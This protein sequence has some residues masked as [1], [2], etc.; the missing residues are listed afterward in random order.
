[1]RGSSYVTVNGAQFNND[2]DYAEWGAI[3]PARGLERITFWLNSNCQDGSGSITVTVN[4]FTSNSLPFTVR[5]GNIFFIAK[6]G[7]DSNNGQ[8]ASS[9]GG[10]NGPWLSFYMSHGKRNATLQAGDIVYIRQGEYNEVDTQGF[11]IYLGEGSGNETSY[12]PGRPLAVVGYP[13]EWPELGTLTE[14]GVWGRPLENAYIEWYKLVWNNADYAFNISAHHVRL[15]GNTFRGRQRPDVGSSADVQLNTSWN[16]EIYGNLWDHSG[17]D[18]W[19]HAIYVTGE[20]NLSQAPH[21]IDIG[22][23]EFDHYIGWIDGAPH[24]AG[25]AIID[26]KNRLY[27]NLITS[28]VYVHD[29]YFHQ[30]SAS[31]MWATYQVHHVYFYNNVVWDNLHSLDGPAS[32]TRG[33]LKISTRDVGVDNDTF[34]VFNNTF[35]DNGG[36]Q[37]GSVSSIAIFQIGG[38]SQVQSTNNIYYSVNDQPFVDIWAGD[39]ASFNSTHDLYFGNSLPSG[40]GITTN[41]PITADPQ[42]LNLAN[43]D[44]RLRE[45]SP[46]VDAG[47]AVDLASDYNG[48]SRP[49]GSSYDLGAF[50]FVDGIPPTPTFVDVPFD[51][52]AHGYIEALYQAGYTTGCNISPL[53]YC[54]ER[55]LDRAEG[56]VFTV[57]AAHG[58]DFI[59]PQPTEQVFA[60]TLLTDWPVD[61]ITQLWEDGYTAGCGTDPLIF[62]PW[63][64]YNK[65]EGAVF[66]L[67]MK[68]GI[69]YVPPDPTGIFSDV[70]ADDW[71]IEWAEAAY[72][73][74]LITACQEDPLEFCPDDALDRA[75]AAY[76]TVQAKGIQIP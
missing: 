10:S 67:R 24:T 65:A 2:S 75:M 73:E 23:N 26:I 70:S 29:N 40:N 16:W 38:H 72:N 14:K 47:V 32:A 45:G 61:W 8:Y 68:Y 15:V 5:S 19:K 25:G 53:M 76:M 69:D 64:S 36:D 56:A 46:A 12:E 50:E 22:W 43:Q 42:F 62:C 54:P 59:P 27:D 51:H 74:E 33:V 7:N 39:G 71:F 35:Y 37:G 58:A 1:M 17:R 41:N 20:I 9:Q 60:D 21:D 34:Y 48:L 18:S 55:I 28:H 13:G 3:G 44:F 57:R 66:A 11:M 49:M 30:C 31:P 63:Q 6:D 4:G 52:W